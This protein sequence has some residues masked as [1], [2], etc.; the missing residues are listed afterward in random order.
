M[1]NGTAD[2][3]W[4]KFTYPFNMTRSP[5]ASVCA[6]L[7]V[8]GT[9]GRAAA[10]RAPACRPGRA[11]V[12][13]GA[14]GRHSVSMPWRPFPAAPVGLRSM[15]TFEPCEPGYACRRLFRR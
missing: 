1:I 11:A 15:A 5:A 10:G 6:G 4:V 7:V 8:V 14:G 9:A 12:G 13:G 2:Y 3:N